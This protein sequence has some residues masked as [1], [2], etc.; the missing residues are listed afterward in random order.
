MH[1][2]SSIGVEAVERIFLDRAGGIAHRIPLRQIMTS[3][4]SLYAAMRRTFPTTNY[5]QG[6]ELIGFEHDAACVT[7]RFAGGRTAHSDLL[8]GSD[9]G[10][11]FVRRQL[12]PEVRA[13]YAGYIAW[14]GL[15]EEPDLPGSAAAVLRNR[16]SF[17]EYPNSH[18]LVYLV[19]GAHEAI[20]HGRRRYNWVWY[21]NASEA[22]RTELLV[23]RDGR[24][25]TT[26]VPPGKLSPQAE[27]DLRAAP[28]AI[29]RPSSVCLSTRRESRFSSLSRTYRSA[30]WPSGVLP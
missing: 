10:N 23:D 21:R 29:Y 11:S 12:M 16:F 15:I 14:R 13:D 2:D 19:P 30:I 18:M 9:G 17:F 8:V 5:H 7:A 3:W 6:A 26:S 28:H 1:Y 24:V 22:R 4:T 20:A 27:A 25:R